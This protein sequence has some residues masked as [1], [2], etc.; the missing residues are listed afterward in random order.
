[1]E[2]ILH[3]IA[4]YS[5]DNVDENLV[6]NFYQAKTVNRQSPIIEDRGLVER[7]IRNY[8]INNNFINYL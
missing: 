4:I 7:P 1:M 8:L 5:L 6:G 2:N 3:S